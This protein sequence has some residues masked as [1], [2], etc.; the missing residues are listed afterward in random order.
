MLAGALVP[1]LVLLAGW[2]AALLTLGLG[3]LACAAAGVPLREQLDANRD[4]SAPLRASNL[5][6]PLKLVLGQPALLK[7]AIISMLFCAVQLS[8]TT[9]MVAYFNG[10]LGY[11][12]VAAGM[13]LAMAQA[14]GAAGRVLWGHVADAWLSTRNA[15]ALLGVLTALAS[16][17]VALLEPGTPLV[18]VCLLLGVL[19]ACAIGWNGVYLAQVARLAPPG[20]ASTATAGAL[21]FTY[22]GMVGGPAAFAWVLHAT[23]SYRA[24]FA[25][26]ALPAIAC[27]V[28]LL[29]PARRGGGTMP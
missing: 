8:V 6:Q 9:Y 16:A 25:A 21:V 10:P 7:L 14:S 13:A 11:S 26:L 28:L 23:G 1:G 22:A 17:A 24:S 27:V 3:C 20:L 18:R 2:Q 29:T 19:G 5:A 12:L 4:A 15:L